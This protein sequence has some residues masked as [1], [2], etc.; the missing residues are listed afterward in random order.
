MR[1]EGTSSLRKARQAL[2]Q[3]QVLC[4]FGEIRFDEYFWKLRKWTFISLPS[5][6]YFNLANTDFFTLFCV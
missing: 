6:P 1:M 5:L 2:V 3:S 4:F